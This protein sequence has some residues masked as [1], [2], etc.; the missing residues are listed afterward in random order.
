[1]PPVFK[2]RDI[3]V[4]LRQRL[5]D[6]TLKQDQILTE[7]NSQM[8]EIRKEVTEVERGIDLILRQKSDELDEPVLNQDGL[9]S[10]VSAL[11]TR[12]L[13][14]LRAFE[15]YMA[16]KLGDSLVSDLT[17][18]FPQWLPIRNFLLGQAKVSASS[19]FEN[20]DDFL[21]PED[22]KVVTF[23]S[24]EEEEKLKGPIYEIVAGIRSLRENRNRNRKTTRD[25]DE[26]SDDEGD[27]ENTQGETTINGQD[28]RVQKDDNYRSQILKF[29]STLWGR[30]DFDVSGD[31]DEIVVGLKSFELQERFAGY[32][33]SFITANQTTIEL[34]VPMIIE[35]QQVHAIMLPTI[36]GNEIFFI[37]YLYFTMI[38]LN[39]IR[40]VF[41]GKRYNKESSQKYSSTVEG[42]R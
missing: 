10:T 5:N 36:E 6:L 20:N 7:F 41:M 13:P 28:D 29:I 9:L 33:H 1:M 19:D 2:H 27:K 34:K 21:I 16:R 31:G 24:L 3:L 42:R 18:S 39:N 14:S 4:V 30:L 15:I 22:S 32:V 23:S 26:N 11:R 40:V 37:Y 25:S 8:L 12:S 17:S 35:Q 38:F